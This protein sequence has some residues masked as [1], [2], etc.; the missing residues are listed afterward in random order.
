MR[1]TIAI[2]L[3]L[4]MALLC[5]SRLGQAQENSDDSAQEKPA[6]TAGQENKSSAERAKPIRPYRLDFWLNELEDGKKINT[7]HYSLNLTAGS[8]DELK[9]G[10]RVPMST[11]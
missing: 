3:V 9:I 10:T 11:G 4:G 2:S 1:K 8:A 5:G 6:K 7:R